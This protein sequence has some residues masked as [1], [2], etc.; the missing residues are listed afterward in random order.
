MRGSSRWQGAFRH[1]AWL[2][3]VLWGEGLGKKDVV[4][5]SGPQAGSAGRMGSLSSSVAPRGVPLVAGNGPA[6]VPLPC[7]AGG[8]SV[9]AGGC[10]G[11]S[12]RGSWDVRSALR[13]QQ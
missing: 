11:D 10:R 5:Q 6:L 12:E 4:L 7:S 8:W 2:T 3:L 13:S 9:S 1:S